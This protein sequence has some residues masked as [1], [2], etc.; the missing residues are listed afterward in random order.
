[1]TIVSK[2][3]ALFTRTLKMCF[4]FRK[5]GKPSVSAIKNLPLT[6]S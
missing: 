4:R 6:S 3:Q 2:L 1:M 5:E